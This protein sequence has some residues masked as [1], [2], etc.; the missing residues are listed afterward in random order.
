MILHSV[1][2]IKKHFTP[3]FVTLQRSKAS[4]SIKLKKKK[5]ENEMNLCS[6]TNLCSEERY[7]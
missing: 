5:K 7:E 3:D 1:G 4:T 2:V 6:E